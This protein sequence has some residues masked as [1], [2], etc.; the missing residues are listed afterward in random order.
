MSHAH[1]LHTDVH[2]L[3]RMRLDRWPIDACT[4][5]APNRGW[6]TEGACGVFF[7]AN[8]MEAWDAGKDFQRQHLRSFK[9]SVRLSY[10]IYYMCMHI[11]DVYAALWRISHA[12]A[13]SRTARCSSSVSG[14]F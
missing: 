11:V 5:D 4:Q 1:T 2:T 14:S 10:D 13:P 12:V 7:G 8:A 6:E 3:I 9:R